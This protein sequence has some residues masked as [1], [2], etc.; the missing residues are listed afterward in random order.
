MEIFLTLAQV[1]AAG[2]EAFRAGRLQAQDPTAAGNSCRYSGPCVIGAALSDDALKHL[3]KNNLDTVGVVRLLKE[4]H[5]QVPTYEW[6][7]LRRLQALH[8]RAMAIGSHED[9]ARFLKDLEENL[10]A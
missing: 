2:L 9:R 7:E 10:E 6:D 5:I 4:G 1:K 3:V 8:D